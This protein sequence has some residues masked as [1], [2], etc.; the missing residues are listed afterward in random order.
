MLLRIATNT[1][2]MSALRQP[3][4]RKPGTSEAANIII[5]AL[6]T[7]E[8]RP[9]DSTMNGNDK[10]VKTGNKIAFSNP[11]TSAPI[12]ALPKLCISRPE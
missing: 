9:N 5:A 2:T 1:A 10:N 11:N 12:K 4:T 3:L 6:S 7:H 8:K